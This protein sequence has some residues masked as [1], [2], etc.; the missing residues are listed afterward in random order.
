MQARGL[1]RIIDVIA[2]TGIRNGS[3]SHDF[4]YRIYMGVAKIFAYPC[5]RCSYFLF[6]STSNVIVV[7]DKFL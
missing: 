2:V 7:I 3:I 6:L 4:F 5:Y 1:T